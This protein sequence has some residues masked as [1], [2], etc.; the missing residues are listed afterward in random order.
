MLVHREARPENPSDV[1]PVVCLHGWPESARMWDTTLSLVADAGRH[2][3]APDL[4][5]YGASPVV[6]PATWAMHMD[7]F[8]EWRR[9]Q[10]LDRV[11][12]VVHDWGGLIGLRWACD[13]PEAVAGLVISDSGFFPD[14]KWHGMAEVMRTPG[15]GE[16]LIE[17]LDE[18]GFV[19][20]MRSASKGMT[21]A[22][23][24]SYW[25]AFSTEERRAAQLELYRSGDFSELEPY[26]GKLAALQVP[27]LLLWGA[28][29]PFAPIA[30]AH[31]LQTE[32]PHA[33]LEV[34]AG[35]GHFVAEDEPERYAAAVVAF[36]ARTD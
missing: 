27:T 22:A 33:E 14:G 8:E 4:P 13:H 2:A 34:I 18:Q 25:E 15:E 17:G 26:V 16:K 24:A 35:A 10:E 21:D 1:P 29:D 3:L 5:G 23:I 28:D 36:L 9:E 11:V 7:A 30:G 19:E 12:L 20:L 31:R 6:R 32:I